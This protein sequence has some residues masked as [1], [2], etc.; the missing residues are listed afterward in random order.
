MTG[1]K[2]SLIAA[3]IRAHTRMHAR[4]LTNNGNEKRMKERRRKK[5]KRR[6][7][8]LL[9]I[10]YDLVSFPDF[11]LRPLCVCRFH[12]LFFFAF[13][14]L[15]RTRKQNSSFADNFLFMSRICSLSHER[16]YIMLLGSAPELILQSHS[17]IFWCQNSS[18]CSV[19]NVYAFDG[20]PRDDVIFAGAHRSRLIIFS[21]FLSYIFR[22][23]IFGWHILFHV[24]CVW[25]VV[26]AIILLAIPT[27]T[28][29][30]PALYSF[31]RADTLSKERERKDKRIKKWMHAKWKEM[32]MQGLRL[33]PLS[34]EW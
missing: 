28:Y 5:W 25:C 30:T 15:R 17:L 27:Y 22:S 14:F 1:E 2:K 10:F 9:D 29:I 8:P 26:C 34:R 32:Y 11:F 6:D 18:L 19:C 20:R 7:F 13:A 12:S 23:V 16:A 21:H 3:P 33:T 31:A 24:A 4:P